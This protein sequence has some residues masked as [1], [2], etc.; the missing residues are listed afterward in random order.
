MAF[1]IIWTISAR[2]DLKAIVQYIKSDNPKAAE[3]FGFSLIKEAESVAE[4]PR[5]TYGSRRKRSFNSRGNLQPISHR[6]Q[7]RRAESNYLH[8][9]NLAFSPGQPAA[10]NS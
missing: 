5:R 3:S 4:F 7:N 10:I 1:R 9:A 8:C 2:K 6:V